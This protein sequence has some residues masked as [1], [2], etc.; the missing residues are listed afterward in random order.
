MQCLVTGDARKGE[1]ENVG[2]EGSGSGH[3]E[4]IPLGIRGKEAEGKVKLSNSWKES[5]QSLF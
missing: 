1:R 5:C 3:T 2:R 4:K